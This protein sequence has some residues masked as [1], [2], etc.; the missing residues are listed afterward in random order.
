VNPCKSIGKTGRP[1]T[2]IRTS[3]STAGTAD[4]ER[5][6]PP[7]TSATPTRLVG[8]MTEISPARHTFTWHNAKRWPGTVELMLH[9]HRNCTPGTGETT[10]SCTAKRMLL[11]LRTDNH[12]T[13]PIPR[14]DSQTILNNER[15]QAL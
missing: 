12:W 7:T 2:G 4:A 1:A 10:E 6:L 8:D 13:F 15:R 3:T 11:Q 5:A 14:P 9:G